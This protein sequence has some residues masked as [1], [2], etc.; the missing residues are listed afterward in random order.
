[1]TPPVE[2]VLFDVGGVLVEVTGVG[3][4]GAWMDTDHSDEEVWHLWL[5][6]A[7]VRAFETGTIGPA[8]FADRLVGEL[9]LRV[10]PEEFLSGFG[11]WVPGP[12][13]GARELVLSLAPHLSRATLSNSNPLHWPR[14]VGDMG[15]GS[16]FDAHFVSHLT[17]R[18]KPDREAFEHAV[19]ELGCEPA[20]VVFVDDNQ[21]NVDAALSVGL[22]AHRSRGP[23]EAGRVLGA[24][25]LLRPLV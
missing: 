2:A 24:Y 9:G 8:E 1:M 22:R 4:L 19:G 21:V 10:A 23:A 12:F 14:I 17:R 5:H 3:T 7:A 11:S 18:I 16:C 6:S 25:G 20:A 15:L 13:P